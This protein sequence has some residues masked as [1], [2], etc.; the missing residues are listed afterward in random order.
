MAIFQRHIYTKVFTHMN[1]KYVQEKP[2]AILGQYSCSIYC[3][4]RSFDIFVSEGHCIIEIFEVKKDTT[5]YRFMWRH[6][7][8]IFRR[9][10][11]VLL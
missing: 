11:E 4:G 9:A 1:Y 3:N 8:S 7:E 6:G 5:R 2:C 10:A